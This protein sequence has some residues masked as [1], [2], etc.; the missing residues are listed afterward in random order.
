M[1]VR[2]ARGKQSP[3]YP[4]PALDN[5]LDVLEALA[6]CAAPQSLTDLARQMERAPGQLFR[7]LNRLEQR[8]Y[9]LRDTASGRYSLSLKLFELAHT[10]AP[11]EHIVRVAAKPMRE[12]AERVKESVHLSVLSHG[13]LVV[14][15]DVASPTRVRLSHEVG[16]QFPPTRSNSGRLLLA[17]MPEEQLSE[18]LAGDPEYATFSRTERERLAGV[19]RKARRRGYAIAD[20]K[21]QA[22]IREIGVVAGNASI[23]VAAAVEIACLNGGQD[24][25]SPE[26]LLPDLQRC[27]EEITAELGLSRSG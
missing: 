4:V 27:A 18:H 20:S 7:L 5:G 12:L 1:D 8:A 10:H 14:L 3:G 17:H 19:L 2:G 21:E 13:R 16:A 26:K 23:G 22:G 15:L 9:V 11:V 6:G 25:C 24:K